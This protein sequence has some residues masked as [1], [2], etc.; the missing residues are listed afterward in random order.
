[1]CTCCIV[2]DGRGVGLINKT[3]PRHTC[4]TKEGKAQKHKK[5]PATPWGENVQKTLKKE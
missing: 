1:M 2:D 4:N 5:K 3:L